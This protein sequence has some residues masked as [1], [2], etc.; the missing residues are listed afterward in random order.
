[1]RF[2]VL[3]VLLALLDIG[4]EA[5]LDEGLLLHYTLDEGT[6]SVAKDKSGNGLSAWA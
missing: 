6:G 1:M 4:W 2:R 5:Q 3:L